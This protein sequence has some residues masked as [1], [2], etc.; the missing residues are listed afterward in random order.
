MTEERQ[1]PVLHAEGRKPIP[2]ILL[3]IDTFSVEK[4]VE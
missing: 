2:Y 3:V 1:Y 4:S